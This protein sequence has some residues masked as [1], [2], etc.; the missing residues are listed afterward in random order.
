MAATAEL[1]K[2]RRTQNMAAKAAAQR[3]AQVMASQNA[4]DH[5]QEEEEEE[6]GDTSF[7]FRHSG[8][9]TKSLSVNIPAI[10]T[11]RITSN[12]KSR[13][14]SLG[15]HF[16]EPVPSFQT[17]RPSSLRIPITIPQLDPQSNRQR[18]NW[19]LPELEP[20]N[21][22]NSGNQHQTG[23]IQDELDMLHEEN[24]NFLD[25]LR[26]AEV[27]CEEAEARVRELEKQIAALGDGVSLETKLLSRKEAALRQREVALKTALQT[28][29]G[30][31]EEIMT[32][33]TEFENVKE[34]AASMIEQLHGAESEAKALRSMTQRMILTQE[35]MEEVVLRRCWLARYW[36]LAAQHGIC[37]DIAVTKYEHWSSL[38]PLPFEV[39]IS[40]GQK[41]KEE[42]SNRGDRDPEERS[43][44]AR[45]LSG[46]TGEGNVESM[47]SVEMGLKELAY[48]EIED[49]VMLALA[50]NRR[51][52]LFRQSISDPRSP[53]DTKYMEAFELGQ[54]EAED[55]LFKEN[56]EIAVRYTERSNL[57]LR[58]VERG[59]ME[60]RKLGIEQ[61]LWEI[62][63]KEFDPSRI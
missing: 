46:L 61:Q 43:K 20:L 38:A 33:Q 14:P 36:G 2:I 31:D 29:D 52:S 13:S 58:E 44:L 10:S 49:A 48:L 56:Q 26:I 32:L 3:L 53:G 22:N 23:A 4:G 8:P 19:Y 37:T 17:G 16:V 24:E 59:L 30:R 34:E 21:I 45:D 7:G 18:D 60:L 11:A 39:V 41:A 35:E 50:Q 5:E 40:A 47:L 9:T 55:V 1:T 15:R 25:K 62:S 57:C 27:R 28:K 12:N 42:S 51:P 6:D 54:E 63:R